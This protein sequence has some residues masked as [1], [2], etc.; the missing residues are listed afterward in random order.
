MLRRAAIL[1][2]H[3]AAAL[4]PMASGWG[5][6]ALPAFFANS[7]RAALLLAILAGSLALLILNID[8]NPLRT[9]T[10][11]RSAGSAQPEHSHQTTQL[12]ALL[13]ASLA[14][15]WFLPY[16]DRH[17]I[18]VFD[19]QPLRWL[20]LAACCAG[21]IIR[22]LALR[23]LGSQFSA[24]ITLQPGHRLI[25]HGIYSIVRHPLYLSLLLAGPGLALIFASQLVFPIAAATVIFIRS[26]IRAEDALLARTFSLEFASYR[27]STRALVPLVF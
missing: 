10:M 14:L 23:T 8:L 3:L 11:S 18:L 1:F 7:A 4:I 16:S 13:L 6:H 22:I 27:A 15:L 5:L 25:R 17:H 2:V 21:G 19:S 24:Y 12:V 9:S 20:G 26:R